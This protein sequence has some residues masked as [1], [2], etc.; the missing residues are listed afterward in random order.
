MCEKW[1]V[2]KNI[3]KGR[4][5]QPYM[6][7]VSIEREFKPAHYEY[8]FWPNLWTH[9][10]S[11]LK[12]V[13]TILVIVTFDQKKNLWKY[14]KSFLFYL[15]YS[16]HYQDIQI[17]IFYSSFSVLIFKEKVKNGMILTSWKSENRC[18]INYFQSSFVFHKNVHIKRLELK[19]WFWDFLLILFQNIFRK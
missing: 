3:Y 7:E 19:L 1:G 8:K 12:C 14:Q 11:K 5:V 4:G 17:F 16:F 15:E 6:G 13:P 2:Q 10:Y 9:I 18:C